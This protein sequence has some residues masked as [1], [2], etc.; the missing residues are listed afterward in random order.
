[1]MRTVRYKMLAVAFLMIFA[2]VAT[3]DKASAVY[4]CSWSE[5]CRG[6]DLCFG[7]GALF[8][9]CSEQYCLMF[10]EWEPMDCQGI[11]F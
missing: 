4:D 11:F 10:G 8:F 7:N 6:F 2:L 5:D 3:S 9:S 1:M